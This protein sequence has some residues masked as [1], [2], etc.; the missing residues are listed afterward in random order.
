MRS[1]PLPGRRVSRVAL[2]D[3][4]IVL[5]GVRKAEGLAAAH[6]LVELLVEPREGRA[7]GLDGGVYS[8]CGTT[9][10]L[11]R[12]SKCSTGLALSATTIDGVGRI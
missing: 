7:T 3:L 12:A 10:S 2:V 11:E 5:G 4:L 1:T 6:D 8:R 9:R